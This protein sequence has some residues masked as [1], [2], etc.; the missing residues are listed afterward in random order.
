ML[1]ICRLLLDIGVLL[2]FIALSSLM[3]PLRLVGVAWIPAAVYDLLVSLVDFEGVPSSFS[4]SKSNKPRTLPSRCGVGP[5]DVTAAGLKSFLD[6]AGLFIISCSCVGFDGVSA[7]F[8]FLTGVS[9]G[10][11]CDFRFCGFDFASDLD[12]AE[13]LPARM[14]RVLLYSLYICATKHC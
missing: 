1:S 9:A 7:Y 12:S 13:I 14:S 4:T 6:I 11:D 5:R 10:I 3:D 2:S 8:V